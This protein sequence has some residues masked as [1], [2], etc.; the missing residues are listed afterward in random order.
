MPTTKQKKC[1]CKCMW[2]DKI[3]PIH[4]LCGF[5]CPLSHPI[6]DKEKK[7]WDK[8]EASIGT[9]NITILVAEMEK[10]AEEYDLHNEGCGT[11]REDECDCENMKIIKSFAK[12]WMVK[13][14]DKWF[15]LTEAHRPYC[16]P[17]GNK[18]ITRILGKKNRNLNSNA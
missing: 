13:V 8:L 3:P 6:P 11:E 17:K 16:S 9:N 7:D 15:F 14:N 10:D 5:D 1:T 18:I 12:E 2:C 4:N